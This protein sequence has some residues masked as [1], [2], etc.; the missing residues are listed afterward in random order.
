MRPGHIDLTISDPLPTS[1]QDYNDTIL[2]KAAVEHL[3]PFECKVPLST[4]TEELTFTSFPE[5]PEASQKEILL[6]LMVQVETGEFVEH[7]KLWMQVR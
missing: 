5:L 1:N 7:C 2:S 3:Q 4:L 6:L